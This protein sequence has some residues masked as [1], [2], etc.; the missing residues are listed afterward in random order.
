MIEILTLFTMAV[1]GLAVIIVFFWFLKLVFKVAFYL[2]GLVVGLI[3]FL[4]FFPI[5][6]ALFIIG[7]KLFVLFIAL[8]PLIAGALV[9]YLLLLVFS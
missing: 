4:V 3:A 1:A 6:L 9:L 7:L 8:V 5:I 2:S